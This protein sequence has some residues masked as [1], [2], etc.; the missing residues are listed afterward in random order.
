MT[1]SHGGKMIYSYGE[2]GD[3]QWMQKKNKIE[4]IQMQL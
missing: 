4:K 1:F 2:E 3:A